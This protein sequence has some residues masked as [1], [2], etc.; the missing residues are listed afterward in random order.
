MYAGEMLGSGFDDE[1]GVS[2][3]V[4][5]RA[6][7]HGICAD[8]KLES[9]VYVSS[10]SFRVWLLANCHVLKTKISVRKTRGRGRW[11]GEMVPI[12]WI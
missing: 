12:R 11:V 8:L 2:V 5:T 9:S 4:C 1:G 10:I 7:I 3:C 6:H